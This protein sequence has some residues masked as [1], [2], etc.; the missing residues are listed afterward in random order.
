MFTSYEPVNRENHSPTNRNP[1]FIYFSE[2][3]QIP[4]YLR[5]LLS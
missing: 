4:S 3:K 2:L 1:A 5:L